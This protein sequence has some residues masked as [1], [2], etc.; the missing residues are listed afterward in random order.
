VGDL[1]NDGRPDLVISHVNEPVTVLRNVSESG[2]HW[3]GVDLVGQDRRDTVGARLVLETGG[4]KLTRYAKGGGSYLSSGDRR[5]LIGLGALTN[6]GRLTVE[7]PSGEPR[8]Q[9]FE[10]LAVDHY[11]RIVQGDKTAYEF[12]ECTREK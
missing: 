7:W 11:Y 3:L 9:H 10:G 1:D 4:R 8:V 6:A 12:P 5:H 2:H